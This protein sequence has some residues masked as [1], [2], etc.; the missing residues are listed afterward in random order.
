MIASQVLF[1]AAPQIT[2]WMPD[3]TLYSLASRY[4][5]LLGSRRPDETCRALFGHHRS[6][7][8]HD[9]PAFVDEFAARTS[10]RLGD[11]RSIILER[12][13]LSFYLPFR[14]STDAVNAIAA[15]RVSGLGG[16]K[17][18][19]G[20]LASKFGAAH[21]LKAC[22]ECIASDFREHGTSYWHRDHQWP[23]VWTCSRHDTALARGL[24]K[25]NSQGRFH[26]LRPVDMEFAAPGDEGAM[27]GA[28]PTLRM[29][30]VG[31][32]SLGNL[33]CGFHF[34]PELVRRVFQSRFR[35]LGLA[36]SSG[37]LNTSEFSIVLASI[38]HPLAMIHGL[39][40]LDGRDT[41]L[42]NQ[43]VRLVQ[44]SRGIA[45]PLRYLLLAIAFFGS[46]PNFL[47]AYQRC[48]S[49]PDV[50]ACDRQVEGSSG[51]SLPP[52]DPRRACVISA[53]EAGSSV[54]AAAAAVGVTVAT[55]M[56]WASAAGLR[57]SRRPK[58]LVLD[59]REWAI[60]RL[61]AGASKATVSSAIQ[62]S[63]QT[64]TH[65]LRTEP[66]LQLA[67]RSARQRKAQRV[68]RRIWI[69]TASRLANPSLGV[70]RHLQPAVFAWLYRN[71]REWLQQFAKALPRKPRSNERGIKWDARDV[72]LAD[73]VRR[74]AL[75]HDAAHPQRSLRLSH[76][77]DA[78]DELKGRLSSLD[79][80]PLTRAAIG[81]TTRR[82]RRD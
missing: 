31:A 23:G 77:C 30:T 43:F 47:D 17:G 25:V 58:K 57:A 70:L 67:W 27:H 48:L 50:P 4:H 71:D 68:A 75:A 20:L 14:S 44:G 7:S 5:C 2:Q 56:V 80:L 49:A 34:E 18:R 16:L 73:K 51:H 61:R 81:D 6:G 82:R 52:S 29:L 66:G 59:L 39:S 1:D 78:V 19:L 10:G 62:M 69:R 55:A 9:F 33:P 63:V 8:S 24:A 45:H 3:E 72:S 21:P 15:V 35:E 79:R 26:W 64:V 60:R 65:L 46:W 36:G 54:S 13:L 28:M 74:A 11:S 38:C 32:I 37:R 53:V 42:L 40:A 22:A 76:L 12:T 41:P